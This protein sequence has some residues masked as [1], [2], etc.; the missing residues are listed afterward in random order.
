MKVYK[1]SP[2]G[3]RY[4]FPTIIIASQNLFD[5]YG[6]NKNKNEPLI[7]EFYFW[8]WGIEFIF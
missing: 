4:I 8:K 6:L 2:G 5:T 7:I 3:Y 1:C